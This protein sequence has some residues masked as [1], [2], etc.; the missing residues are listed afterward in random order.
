MSQ[1]VT[2]ADVRSAAE[3]LDGVAVRTPLVP[4]LDGRL[5]VKPESLQPIGAFKLRGAHAALTAASGEG[6]LRGAVTHSSGNHAQAVA[7]VARALGVPAVIVMPDT[8]PSVKVE[9]TAGFGAEVVSVPPSHEART[10]KAEEL[11]AERG[12]VLV[13]PFD[14]EGVI[15]GQGT[16][17]LEIIADAPDVD[18][19]LV[20]VSGGGLIS[21]VAA[22]VGAVRPRTKVVGVEPEL[23]ADARESLRRG[24]RVAWPAERTGRTIADALRAEQVGVRTYDHIARYVDDIVAVGEEEIR[25]AMRL[26]ARRAR[27]VAEPAG[28]VATAAFLFRRHELPA[29]RTYV[30][31][32]SG[33]NVDPALFAEVVAART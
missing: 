25:E 1:F 4:C 5:L 18:V 24:E 29:G 11:A 21:G 2:V 28:A 33:G 32:L 19:V 8:T 3:R 26:L 17:G 7:Y 9:A 31:V 30:A 13:P 14:D 6:R 15:A 16:V 22:A 23:A 27:L 12:Y 20:P 10:R